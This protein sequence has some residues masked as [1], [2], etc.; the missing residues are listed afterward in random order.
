MTSFFTNLLGLDPN[1]FAGARWS[2]ISIRWVGLPTA[3]GGG[4][5]SLATLA[6]VAFLVWHAVREYRREGAVISAGV[7]RLL[8]AL[9][10]GALGVAL[11]IL[12][13]PTLVVDRS[14]KLKSTAW[15]LVDDSLSMGLEDRS[16]RA[17]SGDPAYTVTRTNDVGRVPSRGAA[18]RLE[19][20]QRVFDASFLNQLTAKHQ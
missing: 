2:D 10:L 16:G 11:A 19:K 15:L 6:L 1:A 17:G 20:A 8:T 9:R 7:R 13:Q 3:P 18:S 12:F 4:W 14:E 5:W